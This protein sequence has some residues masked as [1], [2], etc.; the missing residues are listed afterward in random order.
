VVSFRVN[1]VPRG[2][3]V[4]PDGRRAACGSRPLG[5]GVYLWRLP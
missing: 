2:L 1:S 4:S 5:G 3:A